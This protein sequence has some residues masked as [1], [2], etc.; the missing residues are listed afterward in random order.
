MVRKTHNKPK[1]LIQT[2]IFD[3][4]AGESWTS[5]GALASDIKAN[6]HIVNSFIQPSGMDICTEIDRSAHVEG[7]IIDNKQHGGNR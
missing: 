2:L 5:S 7:A 4:T 3:T 6:L 1:N